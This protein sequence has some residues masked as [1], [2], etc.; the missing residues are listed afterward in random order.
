MAGLSFWAGRERTS[1]WSLSLSSFLLAQEIDEVR[2]CR[3]DETC[4]TTW[5]TVVLGHVLSLGVKGNSNIWWQMK[6]Q[7]GENYRTERV[8][9][10][11][12]RRDQQPCSLCVRQCFLKSN[13]PCY[14]PCVPSPLACCDSVEKMSVCLLTGC[15]WPAPRL[16][17]QLRAGRSCS[18]QSHKAMCGQWWGLALLLAG[19]VPMRFP[20]W[21]CHMCFTWLSWGWHEVESSDS[22]ESWFLFLHPV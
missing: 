20:G 12:L 3:R 16:G 2:T 4:Q 8:N 14:S 9:F 19:K 6:M 22:S 5:N 18:A 11:P 1:C 10:F 21:A 15:S 7:V 17:Q 13:C